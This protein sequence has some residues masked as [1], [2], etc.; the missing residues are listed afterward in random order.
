MKYLIIG[1][2]FLIYG[3]AVDTGTSVTESDIKNLEQE[4]CETPSILYGCSSAS[5]DLYWGESSSSTVPTKTLNL[6]TDIIVSNFYLN[7]SGI[8]IAF[9]NNRSELLYVNI[10]YT[11]KCKVNDWQKVGTF[12]LGLNEYQTEES[13]ISYVNY[14]KADNDYGIITLTAMR[15]SYGTAKE[16]LTWHG[17][18]TYYS[19]S[20]K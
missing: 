8:K 18:Y 13:I 6:G 7:N 17:E 9:K 15:P 1:L 4:T 20:Y 14:C 12:Y 5:Y 16:Y 19:T 2:M 3:C 10:D 11:F